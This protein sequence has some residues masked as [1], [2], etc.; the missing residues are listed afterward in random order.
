M[1]GRIEK[2][3]TPET[4]GR[5]A[6]N[7]GPTQFRFTYRQTIGSSKGLTVGQLVSFQLEKGTAEFAV[8]VRPEESVGS[9]AGDGNK[10]YEIRYR[11][12]EQTNNIRSFR[13]QLW[14]SGEEN[15]EAIV[16]AD[17]ALFRKHDIG[18]QEGP[19][20]CLRLLKSDFE[21][22][23]AIDGTVWTRTVSDKEML[24]HLSIEATSKKSRRKRS[25]Y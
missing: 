23:G 21:E 18:I 6:T 1:T 10:A 16:T 14:R 17:L 5:I 4:P 8:G 22:P 20:I 15:K 7:S 11:G 2:L 25:R 9:L 12:F 19:G 13:F 24:E 3:A